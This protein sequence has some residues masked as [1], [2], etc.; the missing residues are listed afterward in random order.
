MK[1][2]WSIAIAAVLISGCQSWSGEE[3]TAQPSQSQ[4]TAP[5][6]SQTASPTA[7]TQP[8][9]EEPVVSKRKRVEEEVTLRKDTG[10]RTARTEI[11]NESLRSTDADIQGSQEL[12]ASMG[13]SRYEQDFLQHY[14]RHFSDAGSYDEYRP[15]YHYGY[16]LAAQ[17]G[18]SWSAIESQAK[19][20]WEDQH[21]GTWDRYQP[22]I[23]YGWEKAK[24][25][26]G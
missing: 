14:S 15:A 1:H 2:F 18:G 10:E 9:R 23:Q 13:L 5:S 16:A 6:Q 26:R 25:G 21:P 8:Q 12:R 3:P 17:G 19:R 20:S 4:M 24:Q 11:T 22:A 7:K